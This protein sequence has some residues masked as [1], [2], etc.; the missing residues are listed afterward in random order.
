LHRARAFAALARGN[1]IDAVMSTEKTEQPTDKKLKKAR[2]E[3]Q[4]SKSSDIVEVACLGAIL[5]LLTV[6][7]HHLT[8]TLRSI[9][10][11]AL[12]FTSGPRSLQALF[13][14]MMA[15]VHNAIGLLVS[16]AAITL[17]AAVI[18]LAPQ[19]G[20][21]ISMQAVI[22]KFA[23]VN[24]SSGL[25]KIFSLN[26]VIDLA[27][28][29][30]K[31]AVI[32]AVMWLTIRH[33]LP[34]I[35]G[36]IDQS[37]PRLIAT[38]WSVLMQTF[39]VVLGVFIPIAAIDYKL[40]KWMFIRKNKM[41]K[42]EV[43][44]ERKDTDGNPEL[45]GERKRRAKEIADSAPKRGVSFANVVVANPVHYAVALRYDPTEF[46]LPVVLA[47]GTDE[48][49]LQIRQQAMAAG[50][51]IVANPPVARMLHKVPENQPIPEELFDVVAAILRWVDSLSVKV[52]IKE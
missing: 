43:K 25:M 6:S 12:D 48:Q 30:V 13:S 9:V 34:I 26:S 29:T 8:Q 52:S 19:T 1:T 5:M 10:K 31:A 4:T 22:P 50:V 41:S 39:T 35:A 28:M 37:I 20:L 27:K 40:Q 23:A 44:R 45:K 51:P 32:L 38:L 46:P 36:A 42:D 21:Q 17:G 49:A 14:A 3:G 24:P 15:I 18:A 2:E 33:S 11:I 16:V 47:K 7:E